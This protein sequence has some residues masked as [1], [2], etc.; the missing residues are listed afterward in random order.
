MSAIGKT[1]TRSA[2][3]ATCRSGKGALRAWL[4]WTPDTTLAALV[5]ED[6]EGR[7]VEIRGHGGI[8]SGWAGDRLDTALDA[9]SAPT[10][11]SLH[12]GHPVMPWSGSL[13]SGG[14]QAV[15]RALHSDGLAVIP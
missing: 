13:R 1:H 11:S 6:R 3:P 14:D 12:A 5:I 2:S 8:G 4:E 9:L 10:V 7:R 15:L